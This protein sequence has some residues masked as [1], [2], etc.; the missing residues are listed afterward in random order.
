MNAP[1]FVAEEDAFCV[2]PGRERSVLLRP[3]APESV[4]RVGSL[5]ALN[6]AG[7]LALEVQASRS[8]AGAPS[9]GS[10]QEKASR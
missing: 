9:L 5:T 7:R 6:L 8:Q 1:G 4:F 2:E 10:P 3:R